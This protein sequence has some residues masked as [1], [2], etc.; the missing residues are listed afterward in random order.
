MAGQGPKPKGEP[1]WRYCRCG[2]KFSLGRDLIGHLMQF[3][4]DWPSEYPDTSHKEVTLLQWEKI[5]GQKLHVRQIQTFF[6]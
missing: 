1:R 3:N 2:L 4:V 5:H 6:C